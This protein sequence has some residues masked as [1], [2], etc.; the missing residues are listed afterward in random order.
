[1]GFHIVGVNLGLG[2][3]GA[4]ELDFTV[5]GTGFNIVDSIGL[6]RYDLNCQYYFE[7]FLITVIV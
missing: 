5:A 7:G 3:R 4:Q 6:S 2:F 1:M